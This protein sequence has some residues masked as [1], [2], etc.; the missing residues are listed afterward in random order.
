[1]LKHLN[2]VNQNPER[3]VILGA[4]GFVGSTIKENLNR[5]NIPLL[6]VSREDID[7]CTEDASE[8][9]IKILKPS[10][11]LLFISAKAPVKNEMML[12]EN[13]KMAKAVCS[14]LRTINVSHL[15]YISS[16][17]VY[18]DSD[19]PLSEKSAA[20]PASLHG[21]MHLT[22]EIMLKNAFTGPLC[23]LRP[24]LIFGD[25]DPHNGYGPNSFLRLAVSGKDLRLFGEGEERRDHVWIEDVAE[26][27][28]KSILHKSVGTLNIATGRLLSFNEIAKTILTKVEASSQ[29]TTSDRVGP[30]PHNGYRAFDITDMH[31]AFP[32]FKYHT[33]EQWLESS[34]LIDN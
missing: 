16:D 33:L 27:A 14:A 15:V 28:V 21:A 6:A 1:M 24:T 31:I 32:D 13:I 29:I 9:L 3:V 26:V 8:K 7:L 5:L 10:D 2:T 12:I 22:R 19:K 34:T 30:M 25:K 11:T 4:A 18:A 20:E 23:V 17:A